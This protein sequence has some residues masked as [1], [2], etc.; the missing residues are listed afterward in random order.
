MQYT[1]FYRNDDVD[2]FN[3]KALN[4]IPGTVMDC[5]ASDTISEH[6]IPDTWT[7]LFPLAVTEKTRNNS[8]LK[9]NRMQFPLTLAH[10]LTIHKSQGQSHKKVVVHIKKTLSRELLYVACSRATSLNGLF[11]I[12]SFKAPNKLDENGHL[13]QEMKRW[14]KPKV[15][16]QFKHLHH[17][18]C[19]Q[20]R[21]HN[22][23]SLEKHCKLVTNDLNFIS[24]DV[25]LF[26]ETWMSPLDNIKI[27]SFKLVTTLE[28]KR[29]EARLSKA[30]SNPTWS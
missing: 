10:A 14:K 30:D 12:G 7:P 13:A 5:H 28:K 1:F 20:I 6:R 15:I 11:I 21:F 3:T 9:R 27:H 19:F 16:P 18:N 22:E 2:N 17:S 29:A 4:E 23:Q 26:G 8:S 25:L 24:S